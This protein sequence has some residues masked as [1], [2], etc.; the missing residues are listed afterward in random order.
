LTAQPGEGIA[1]VEHGG[2]RHWVVFAGGEARPLGCDLTDLLQRPVAEAREIVERGRDGEPL[3]LDGAREL[4]PVD[5]QPVWAAGVTYERSLEG[6]GEESGE[7]DLYDRVYTH[8]RAE[9]FFKAPAEEVVGPGDDVGIRADSGWDVPEPEL[10]VV[11]TSRLEVLGYT[12]GNDMSSRSIEG[13]N[14]LYLPQAK[15]YDKACSLGP[16]IVPEWWADGPFE[17]ALD[18]ERGGRSIVSER[19]STERMRRSF[20]ELAG[21]LGRALEFPYGAVLMTGTGIVPEGSFTLAAGDI[22][23]IEVEG[24]GTLRN[25]V[26]VVGRAR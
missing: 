21:W 10:A 20:E 9:L 3:R 2:E 1:R 13:E 12:I 24:V 14:A 7:R 22:V 23:T 11:L 26:V 8:E 17:I 25:P 4:A 16:R 15:I 18:V 19:T 5:R 6:R